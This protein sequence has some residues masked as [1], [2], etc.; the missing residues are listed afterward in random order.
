M[1]KRFA[2]GIAQMQMETAEIKK[3][4]KKIAAAREQPSIP[5]RTQRRIAPKNGIK[6][7]TGE[8]FV[9]TIAVIKK[10]K[11]ESEPQI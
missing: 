8:A 1:F 6:M 5:Q 4:Q 9:N 11:A 2:F 3:I 10:E 7:R